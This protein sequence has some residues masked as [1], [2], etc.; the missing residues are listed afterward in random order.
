MKKLESLEQFNDAKLNETHVSGVMGGV[1]SATAG[2][3]RCSDLTSTGC[4]GYSSD[5]NYENGSFGW[6]GTY[7]AGNPC[8]D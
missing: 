1:Q 8:G 4:M 7:E 6:V 5:I 3:T 2:G